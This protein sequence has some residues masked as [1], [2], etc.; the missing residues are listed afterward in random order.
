[1][2]RKVKIGIIQ[3]QS[4]L[5]DVTENIERAK[6]KIKEVANQGAQVICLP[7][8]FATGYDLVKLEEKIA[9]MSIET[10][11]Y[12]KEEMSQAAKDNEVYL[13]APF[14]EVKDVPGIVYNS[15]FL[16]DDEG[17]EV[18]SFQKSHLW[19]LERLYFKEGTE[20]PVFDTKYGK[21]GL[22]IC[23]DAGFPEPSR[24]LCLK[25]AE[26]VFYPS[27]WRVQDEDMWDLNL[28]QR[29]LENTYFTVGVNQYDPSEATQLFGKSKICDP[30]GKVLTELPKDEEASIVYEI[31]LDEV[32]NERRDV[33]YLRDRKS[34]YYSE[35]LN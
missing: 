27:A 14:G 25:G 15:A 30:R 12:V 21:I 11:S 16:F 6:Q 32:K 18:G 3:M 17:N 7:E 4:K 26:I 33:P 9:E 8:L 24:I 34:H 23:Y 31:D 13:I 35:L 10:Y 1:M 5:A 2:S 20:Y 19:A 22:L 29:A 28:R